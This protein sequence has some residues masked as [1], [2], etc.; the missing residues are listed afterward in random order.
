MSSITTLFEREEFLDRCRK[1]LKER[2]PIRSLFQSETF[3]QSDQ[4]PLPF[5]FF[6]ETI[7]ALDCHRLSGNKQFLSI[8]EQNIRE[9]IAVEDGNQQV[10]DEFRNRLAAGWSCTYLYKWRRNPDASQ[11]NEKRLTN[12]ITTSSVIGVAITLFYIQLLDNGTDP[13]ELGK[14]IEETLCR[15]VEYYFDDLGDAENGAHIKQ[16]WEEREEP[17]NHV[18]IYTLLLILVNLIRPNAEYLTRAR[19]LCRYIHSFFHYEDNGCVFWPYRSDPNAKRVVGERYWKSTWTVLLISLCRR[20][21]LYFDE[22]DVKAVL[23]SVDTNMIR[24]GKIYESLCRRDGRML[25]EEILDYHRTRGQLTALLRFLNF[26]HLEP[27]QPGMAEKICNA[28]LA[29]PYL[30]DMVLRF[31]SQEGTPLLEGMGSLINP[32]KATLTFAHLD[33]LPGFGGTQT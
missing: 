15:V 4:R 2:S 6:S 26:A 24:D 18:A 29:N 23:L 31:D 28:M 27:L 20:C 11:Q 14:K 22:D 32:A 21:G 13:G 10:R 16:P 25:S 8:A 30:H 12:D 33:K 1:R 7:L 19:Q 9:M 17:L 3:L 5:V